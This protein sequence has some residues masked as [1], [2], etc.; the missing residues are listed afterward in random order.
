MVEF[1]FMLTH[2]DVTVPDAREVLM[3]LKAWRLEHLKYLGFKDIGLPPAQLKDLCAEMHQAGYSVMLEVVSEH[4]ED[5][6]RSIAAAQYIGVDYV[7]G[8]VDVSGGIQELAGSGIRYFPFAGT[9]VGHPSLLRGS[10]GGIP[11]DAARICALEGV[12]GIDLLAYRYDGDP[13]ALLEDVVKAAGLPVI[14]AG[15]IDSADRIRAV[16]QKGA[17]GFT[18]GTAIFDRTLVP[19]GNLRSQIEFAIQAAGTAD[20]STTNGEAGLGRMS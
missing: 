18:I 9:I 11:R 6:R 10:I 16:A 13:E 5:E 12:D 20:V 17:W 14:A 2:D 8:G 19:G 15:S 7:L 3:N 4:P 1:I